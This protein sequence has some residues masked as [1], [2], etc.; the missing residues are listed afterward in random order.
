MEEDKKFLISKF[1]NFVEKLNYKI[2]AVKRP[3][4]KG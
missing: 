1:P 4:T 3:N 2:L